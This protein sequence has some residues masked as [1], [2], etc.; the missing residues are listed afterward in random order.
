MHRLQIVWTSL[1]ALAA[2]CV[3]PAVGEDPGKTVSAAPSAVEGARRQA[4]L[5]HRVYTATLDAMHEHYFHANRAVLPARAMEDVFQQLATEE[6][7]E[8]R[9]IAVNT[10]PMSVSHTPRTEFEKQAAE[11]LGSGKPFHEK[12]EPTAYL[13]AAPIPLSGGCINC[14]MGF[15]RDTGTKP[16]VAGLVIRVPLEES[17]TQP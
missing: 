15:M 2:V 6:K 3:A 17:R 7:I 5:L 13:R 4:Q 1:V 10:Q 14:H 9:W 11:I 16:R 12:V 8:A